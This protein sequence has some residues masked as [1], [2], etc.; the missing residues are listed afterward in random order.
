MSELQVNLKDKNFTIAFPNHSMQIPMYTALSLVNSLRFMDQ[1]GVDINYIVE[2]QNSIVDSARNNLV[3]EFLKEPLHQTLIFIDS[4]M[5]WSP[6]DLL[7][8]CAWSTMYPVVAGMYSTKSED[9]KFLGDYWKDPEINQVMGNEHGLIKMTG[10]GLG[11][12]AIHRSVFETMMPTTKSYKDPRSE[13]PVYRFFSTTADDGGFVGEDIYFFRRWTRE[14]G[15]ELWID[16]EIKL[17][18]IGQKIYKGDVTHSITE[19][20]K[21]LLE[22]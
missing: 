12:C 9:P 10:I 4:D 5:M 19:Y 15:G 20:N 17:G 7:R 6:D 21:R 8:L 16:P 2:L 13:T 3:H 1:N 14:F 22:G 18:H 11:F